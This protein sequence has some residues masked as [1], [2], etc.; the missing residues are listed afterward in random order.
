M[1][2]GL[3]HHLF[4]SARGFAA[5]YSCSLM[6]LSVL[7]PL[8][9]P[10]SKAFYLF[11]NLFF[12]IFF[13]FWLCPF[14]T[15]PFL[16]PPFLYTVAPVWHVFAL[17]LII[18]SFNHCPIDTAAKLSGCLWNCCHGLLFPTA[19][20]SKDRALRLCFEVTQYFPFHLNWQS[21]KS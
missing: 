7:G 14:L 1:A 18:H 20:R 13:Y 6:D 8:A 16:S 5:V 2:A 21:S 17:L 12:L 19:C 10:F 11:D 3:P 4:L 15:Y 9:S